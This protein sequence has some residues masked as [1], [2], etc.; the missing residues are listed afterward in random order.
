MAC[1]PTHG[2]QT[3]SRLVLLG[4]LGFWL[5]S[6]VRDR[7][8]MQLLPSW[9]GRCSLDRAWTLAYFPGWYRFPDG[10]KP[11]CLPVEASRPPPWFLP[12]ACF[13]AVGMSRQMAQDYVMSTAPWIVSV[14]GRTGVRPYAGERRFA[15]QFSVV[16]GTGLSLLCGLAVDLWLEL[17]ASCAEVKRWTRYWQPK[18][19][20]TKQGP[21]GRALTSEF[22]TASQN[23]QTDVFSTSLIPALCTIAPTRTAKVPALSLQ[24]LFRSAAT[25]F[26]IVIVPGTE[27]GP[28]R[29]KNAGRWPLLYV[30]NPFGEHSVCAWE[31]GAS[32]TIRWRAF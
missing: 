32:R 27:R 23:E 3:S 19:P 8:S 22:P 18:P 21:R 17:G 10:A 15:W 31:F 30:L 5:R 13:R 16:Y 20:Q 11:V 26:P 12:P 24:A 4:V 2:M 25:A 29:C 14:A 9:H 7:F 6:R 1:L 28:N